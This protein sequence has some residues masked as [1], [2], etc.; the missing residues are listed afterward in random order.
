MIPRHVQIMMVI[1]LVAVIAT[2]SYIYRL[3]R[4]TEAHVRDAGATRITPPAAS[5]PEQK[6][7]L[8]IAYDDDGVFR[9]ET[10]TAA[11]PEEPEA[12]ARELLRLLIGRYGQ[13]PS[14]HAVGEGSD[15]RSVFLLKNG[16]AVVDLNAAFAETHRS[17][18]EAETF[19]IL[20]LVET[21]KENVPAITQV[22]FLVD[23][24]ERETLA[25]HADLLGTYDAAAVHATVEG[26]K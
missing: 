2:G 21:L 18:I 16:L 3:E 10:R 22:K 7:A 23:G 17:G 20:S 5:G 13:K 26:L 15:V 12:H 14:P 11:L 9:N 24:K 4:R 6:V 25:G 19:T 8:A 1:L